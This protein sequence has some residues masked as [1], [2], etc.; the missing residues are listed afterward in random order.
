MSG[1]LRVLQP[2]VG[3]LLQLD[4]NSPAHWASSWRRRGLLQPGP[5]LATPGVAPTRPHDSDPVPVLAHVGAG[6]ARPQRPSILHPRMHPRC[7]ATT[8]GCSESPRTDDSPAAA[9]NLPQPGAE[10]TG[11]LCPPYL[12]TSESLGD[13]AGRCAPPSRGAAR[14]SLDSHGCSLPRTSRGGRVRPPHLPRSSARRLCG[15]PGGSPPQTRS[16]LARGVWRVVPIGELATDRRQHRGEC[17]RSPLRDLRVEP[18]PPRRARSPFDSPILPGPARRARRFADFQAEAAIGAFGHTVGR[19]A[20]LCPPRKGF[21]ARAGRPPA[22]RPHGPHPLRPCGSGPERRHCAAPSR[23]CPRPPRTGSPRRHPSRG[24][25]DWGRDRGPRP[26]R[27]VDLR[28]EDRLGAVRAASGS[29][30]CPTRRA[31]GPPLGNTHTPGPS[32]SGI[33][34]ARPLRPVR[35]RPHWSRPAGGA[36]ARDPCPTRGRLP[37]PRCR[38]GRS[39]RGRASSPPGPPT[40]ATP[41]TRRTPYAAGLPV[42]L[43]HPT[44]ICGKWQRARLHALSDLRAGEL[45]HVLLAPTYALALVGVP[46][47]ATGLPG[48]GS[49]GGEP[50]T[51]LR[52]NSSREVSRGHSV[53]SAPS[54]DLG[55]YPALHHRLG[56]P[57]G[58]RGGHVR[59][60]RQVRLRLARRSGGALTGVALW[61]EWRSLYRA[62]RTR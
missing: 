26:R 29:S 28:I 51:V 13:R 46:V 10:N 56:A 43:A 50:G 52:G 17:S 41:R 18:T 3:E 31:G 19:R 45:R 62:T 32:E 37:G 22:S 23:P 58:P 34:R 49:A 15:R 30:R 44:G 2:P 35:R 60:D 20:A 48:L 54:P 12:R 38:R 40:L 53:H 6:P 59:G 24:R 61:E 8:A 4:S 5:G 55:F 27:P 33:R 25:A 57:C 39:A 1:G 47:E 11:R 14:T 42:L 9:E 36:A 21:A 16:G 7:G